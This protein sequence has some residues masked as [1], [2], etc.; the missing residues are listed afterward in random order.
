MGVERAGTR[1]NRGGIPA[2]TTPFFISLAAGGCKI[3]IG[4]TVY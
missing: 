2:I 1:G 3:L 4:L